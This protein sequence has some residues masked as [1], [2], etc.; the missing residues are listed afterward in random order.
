[1]LECKDT[2]FDKKEEDTL[3][4][5]LNRNTLLLINDDF[6]TFDFV[7]EALVDVC[8]HD[9]T[10]AEQCAYITH[11]KGKCDVKKG[12]MSTIKPMRDLLAEKGLKVKIV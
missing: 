9:S 11:Y 6:H 4:D 2:E 1:M 5:L 8:R 3:N 10:Q 7:V 12:K